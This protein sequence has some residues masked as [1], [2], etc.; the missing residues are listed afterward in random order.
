MRE[1]QAREIGVQPFITR[2]EFVGERESGHEAALLQPKDRRK[3]SGKMDPFNRCERDQ[4]RS[5]IGLLVRY[6]SHSPF[7]FAFDRRNGFYRLEKVCALLGIFDIRINEEAIR[8]GMDIFHHD[9]EPVKAPG[10]GILHLIGEPLNQIFVHNPVGASKK[11]ENVHDEKTFI[12][13][14]LGLPIELILAQV[15]LLRRPETALCLLVH[16][17]N[18]IVLDGKQHK[19]VHSWIK[20]RFRYDCGHLVYNHECQKTKSGRNSIYTILYS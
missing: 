14:Q 15:H 9:L 12:F 10:F 16:L 17:P 3:R 20:K 4:A 2:N 5:E 1:E 13:R 11:G 6:P 7:R 8:F 19:A 18:I